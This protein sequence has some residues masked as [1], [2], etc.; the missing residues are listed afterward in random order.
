MA[1]VPSFVVI[2]FLEDRVKDVISSE[3]LIGKQS[4]RF[5]R[6]R[7]EF[8]L[9]NHTRHDSEAGYEVGWE[10]HPIRIIS[11]KGNMLFQICSFMT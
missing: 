5:P 3:W 6:E 8:F 2:E 11:M 4:C 1:S 7:S 9:K 10:V